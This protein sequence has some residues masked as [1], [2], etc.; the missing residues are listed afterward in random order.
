MNNLEPIKGVVG[1]RCKQC[2]MLLD[3][4]YAGYHNCSTVIP[5]PL[6]KK[7]KAEHDKAMEESMK[8]MQPFID[9]LVRD[10]S[11]DDE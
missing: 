3:I 8:K 10:S 2:D 11:P 7:E 1:Y 4:H 5:R 9:E 6:T